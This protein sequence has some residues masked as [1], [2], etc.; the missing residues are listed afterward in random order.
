MENKNFSHFG[1]KDEDQE[2]YA[3]AFGTTGKIE[4]RKQAMIDGYSFGDRLLEGVMFIITIQDD[5]SLSAEVHPNYAAYFNQL[6]T[7]MWLERALENA[8]VTDMFEGM[9]GAVDINLVMDDGRYNFE[10]EADER[11]GGP[12]MGI[13]ITQADIDS[14]RNDNGF[15]LKDE[16]LKNEIT[17]GLKSMGI[18]INKINL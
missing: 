11:R 7:Q 4:P 8:I 2:M 5:G 16:N 3:E 14:G 17:E 1:L 13:E 9:D 12:A 10:W 18:K 6:N 15:T